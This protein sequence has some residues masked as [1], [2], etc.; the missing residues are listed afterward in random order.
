MSVIFGILVS[1]S[2]YKVRVNNCIRIK[3][4]FLHWNST[5]QYHLIY[6]SYFNLQNAPVKLIPY[7]F[8]IFC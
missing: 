8:T 3:L 4:F 5:S 7:Y 2:K 1:L 6:D